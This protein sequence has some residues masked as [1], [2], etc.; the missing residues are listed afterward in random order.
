MLVGLL[1][2]G[3]VPV[4]CLFAYFSLAPDRELLSDGLLGIQ[5]DEVEAY[6]RWFDLSG[7]LR[8]EARTETFRLDRPVDGDCDPSTPGIASEWTGARFQAEG[9]DREVLVRPM[10]G[11]EGGIVVKFPEEEP[12]RS[13]HQVLL[14]PAGEI[15][16]RRK[17]LEIVATEAGLLTPEIGFVRMEICGRDKGLYVKEERMDGTFLAKH[18][19]DRCTRFEQAFDADRPDQLLPDVREAWELIPMFRTRRAWE[20]A[21]TAPHWI[22]DKDLAAFLLMIWLE[23][24]PDLLFEEATYAHD[25]TSGRAI[26]L[27]R[28]R[29]DTLLVRTERT[30]ATGIISDRLGDPEFRA[31]LRKAHER[32]LE[33]QW[34]LKERFAAMDKAWLPVLSLPD[35]RH[36]QGVNDRIKAGLLDRLEKGD[37]LAYFD[38]PSAMP[39]GAAQLLALQ[40]DAHMYLPVED[41]REA[42]REI[43]DAYGGWT[44][45]DTLYFAR[46]KYDVATDLVIPRGGHLVLL[47]GARLFL[48]PDASVLCMGSFHVRGTRLNPVFIRPA[49]E[50]DGFGTIAVVGDGTFACAINGVRISGGRGAQL[51]GMRFTGMLS[52][53]G[54]DLQLTNS[55]FEEGKAEDLVNVRNAKVRIADCVFIDSAGDLL[56]LDNAKGEVL[57]CAFEGSRDSLNGDGLD[58]GHSRVLVKECR[59]DRLP[60]N[61]ISIG[62]ASDALVVGCR[63]VDNNTA[64]AVKDLSLAHVAD[65]IFEGNALVVAVYRK[66]PIYGGAFLKLYPNTYVGNKADRRVDELSRLK[67]EE[68]L[69][70]GIEGSYSIGR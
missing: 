63:F 7:T 38:L 24:R 56:D 52:S 17:Y 27:Y 68:R 14:A 53:H 6:A 48:G 46:G 11:M 57:T 37:P 1:I 9:Y 33:D 15:S 16:M 50:A 67:A 29:D 47:P 43:A 70:D 44:E 18:R 42:L 28:S 26:P 13:Q 21:H 4:V 23:D 8:N 69:P 39:A 49:R 2:S 62:E 54:A 12:F 3:G 66:R 58:L 60:D 65:N 64:I 51:N 25:L 19:L 35:Q 36:V 55:I 10:R 20:L 45:G 59:F 22:T 34:R 61:A 32:L 5:H 41:H 40:Q 30:L 31:L